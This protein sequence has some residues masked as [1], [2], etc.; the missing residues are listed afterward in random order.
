MIS[1]KKVIA[2]GVLASWAGPWLARL[3]ED[4]DKPAWRN[5]YRA[6]R[7]NFPFPRLAIWRE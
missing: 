6:V 3:R 1:V 5:R 2:S 4:S 7:L